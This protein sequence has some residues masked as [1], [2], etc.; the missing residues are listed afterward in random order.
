M[1]KH[2]TLQAI[3]AR[4]F[5]VFAARPVG[6]EGRITIGESL[7]AAQIEGEFRGSTWPALIIYH[8]WDSSLSSISFLTYEAFSEL[9][10]S[11]LC[12]SVLW[13][14]IEAEAL[15]LSLLVPL[16]SDVDEGLWLSRFEFLH[17][18]LS[19]RKRSAVGSFLLY[20]LEEHLEGFE[21]TFNIDRQ[22]IAEA[23]KKY[24]GVEPEGNS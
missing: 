16:R 23:I 14:Q 17:Q 24:W 22:A 12:A 6:N 15:A 11:Y 18:A 13:P 9:L 4:A 20:L 2:L 19:R 1:E 3:L 5:E 10:P 21:F 8:K 7:E